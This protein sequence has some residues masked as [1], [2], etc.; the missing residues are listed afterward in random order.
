[1]CSIILYNAANGVLKKSPFANV[2]GSPR[3]VKYFRQS[4]YVASYHK[5]AVYRFNAR[6]GAPQGKF[7]HAGPTLFRPLDLEFDPFGRDGL[8]GN[9][10][11][12]SQNSVFQ[13][14]RHSGSFINQ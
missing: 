10:Y 9:L 11:V 4:I 8:G 7:T 6:T 12:S 3:G 1:M 5:H 2:P 14:E 13:Y